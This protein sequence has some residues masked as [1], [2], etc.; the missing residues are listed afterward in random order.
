MFSKVAVFVSA[1]FIASA[2][3]TPIENSCN[4]GAV[5]CCQTLNA[6]GSAEGTRLLGLVDVVLQNF[7]GQVGFQCNPITVIGVG[8]GANCASQPVCCEN[9]TTNQ[10]IGVNCSPITVGF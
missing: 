3:A 8:S 10:L 4:S 7:S 1:L 6:P 2:V 5:Q 9:V